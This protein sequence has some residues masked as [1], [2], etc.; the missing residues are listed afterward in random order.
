M[1]RNAEP[2]SRRN[3]LGPDP[4]PAMVKL[5]SNEEQVTKNTPPAFLA[6]ARD[7]TVVSPGDSRNFYKAL[8]AHH[9]AAE[10]LELPEGGHGLNG[11]KGP[12]WQAWQTKSLAWLAA[13]K[14]I[15]ARDATP[16]N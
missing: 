8:R 15:P 13:Q 4:Q 2:G 11:Y 3:L 12:M 10:Y 1:Q 14:I 16:S 6:H 5:F 7:D 9:V